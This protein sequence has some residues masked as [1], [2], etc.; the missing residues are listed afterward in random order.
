MLLPTLG[1]CQTLPG[2][3]KTPVAVAEAGEA[4]SPICAHGCTKADIILFFRKE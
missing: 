1:T 2:S 4:R 3:Y